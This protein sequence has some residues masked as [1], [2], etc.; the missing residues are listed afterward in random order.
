MPYL[1]KF[2]SAEVSAREQI[3][4]VDELINHLHRLYLDSQRYGLL[5]EEFRLFLVSSGE[6]SLIL[7][8]RLTEYIRSL[9]KITQLREILLDYNSKPGRQYEESELNE[10]LKTMG[11]IIDSI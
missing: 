5:P 6:M 10:L 7:G 3:E 2:T 11:L 1:Y 4:C 8:Y 9:D